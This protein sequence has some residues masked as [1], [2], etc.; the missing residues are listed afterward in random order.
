MDLFVVYVSCLTLLCCLSLPCSL[1]I[2]CRERAD[3]LALWCVVF[4]SVFV[5]FPYS[6]PDQVWYLIVS[7]L[8]LCLKFSSLLCHVKPSVA[9]LLPKGDFIFTCS[10]LFIFK[11]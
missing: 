7:I 10:R 4:S 11:L 9:P 2:T 6:V 3:F 8:D 1:V 5:I